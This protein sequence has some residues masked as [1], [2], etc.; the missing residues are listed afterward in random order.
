MFSEKLCTVRRVKP[1]DFPLRSESKT[2]FIEIKH[3]RYY[4]S[5]SKLN[6]R[7]EILLITQIKD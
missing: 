3:Y 2:I 1:I 6:I 5:L 7:Q 4:S